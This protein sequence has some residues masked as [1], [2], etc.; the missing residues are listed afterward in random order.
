MKEKLKPLKPVIKNLAS[1]FTHKLSALEERYWP[2][3]IGI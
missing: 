3:E 2:K 1:H